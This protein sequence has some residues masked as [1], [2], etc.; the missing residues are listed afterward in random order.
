MS[1]TW[2][3]LYQSRAAWLCAAGLA[4]GAMAWLWQG[5]RGS[6]RRR[7]RLQQVGTVAQLFLHPVKSCRGL[8]LN[9]AECTK[10]GLKS[11]GLR[12]RHW[13]VVKEDGHMVTARQEPQ[14]VL[15]SVRGEDSYLVFSAPEMKELR[16]PLEVAKTNIV[17]NCRIFGH[18]VQGRDCGNEIGDWITTFLKSTEPY[19]LVHFEDQLKMRNC[20]DEFP[21]YDGNDQVAYPDLSPILLLSE[22]SLEDLNSRMEKKVKVQNFRPNIVVTGCGAFEEDTW[23]EILIGTLEMK[24]ALHS[25]RCIL[26]TV[27]PDTGIIS[28]RDPLDTLKSYRLCDPSEKHIYKAAPLFGQF[29]G[30]LK[31][32]ILKVGDPVYKIVY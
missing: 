16:L 9:E 3:A 14:L 10:Q 26:T 5:R 23:D 8:A 17:Q 18:D 30:I 21:E 31:P 1:G 28:R 22:A 32:G 6:A 2:G 20:K 11:A 29:F 7:V 12:D 15:I 24:R 27:D 13:M 25:P 4:L 19:R